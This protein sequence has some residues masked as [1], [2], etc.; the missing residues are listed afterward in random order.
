MSESGTPEAILSAEE[1]EFE[2]RIAARHAGVG[3][4]LRAHDRALRAE[5]ERLTA[6]RDAFKTAYEFYA[7]DEQWSDVNDPDEAMAF[8]AM[9]NRNMDRAEA[10]DARVAALTEAL[11]EAQGALIA[12]KGDRPSVHTDA[13]WL[14][15]LAALD[16]AR[17]VLGG[18][19][20]T[21]C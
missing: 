19:T 12:V 2:F 9:A 4:V 13:V 17:E 16:E 11:R 18:G 5:V 15:V 14:A 3:A 1:W 7:D 10:A 6:E 21:P 8:A 20:D